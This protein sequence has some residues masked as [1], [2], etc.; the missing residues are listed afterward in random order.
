MQTILVLGSWSSGTTAVAGYVQKLG[1]YSCPPHWMTNDPRT[2]DS[3]ES[4]ELRYILTKC[5]DEVSFNP[6]TPDYAEVFKDFMRGW[7]PAKQAEAKASGAR[8]LV[9]KHPLTAFFL[10]EI[11]EICNPKYLLVTRGFQDIETTRM[12]RGW[13]P[14][15]GQQGAKVIYNVICGT[16]MQSEKSFYAISFRDFLHSEDERK[17]MR[18][19][20]A[21]P[22]SDEDVARAEGWI[23]YD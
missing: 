19:Y 21:I 6:T 4:L 22:G 15:L 8:A 9:L 16:L 17:R 20:L 23:R 7:F 5:I 10:N 11:D 1:A 12:R 18:D 3:Y 13:H 2:R 14:T